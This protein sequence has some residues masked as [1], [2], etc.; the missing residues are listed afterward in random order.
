VKLLSPVF[1]HF[2]KFLHC[3]TTALSPNLAA[4]LISQTFFGFWNFY[5]SVYNR[6]IVRADVADSRV[7]N[8]NVIYHSARFRLSI[9]IEL[10]D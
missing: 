1:F 10:L 8:D 6:Q 7:D 5:C 3:A 4:F 2:W 9:K